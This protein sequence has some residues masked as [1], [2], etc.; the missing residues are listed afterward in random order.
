M[1]FF[2][3]DNG[4]MI[5]INEVNYDCSN[6]SASFTEGDQEKVITGSK[7]PHDDFSN[8]FKALSLLCNKKLSSMSESSLPYKLSCTGVKYVSAEKYEGYKLSCELSFYRMVCDS[9]IKLMLFIPYDGYYEAEDRNGDLIHDPDESPEQLTDDEIDDI[10]DAFSEAYQYFY[11]NKFKPDE[12]PDLFS[13]EDL[14]NSVEIVKKAKEATESLLAN[15]DIQ[16]IK[17]G[18]QIVYRRDDEKSGKGHDTGSSGDE[19][20][21]EKVSKGK[22]KEKDGK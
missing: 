12:Q 22:K 3:R 1:R 20:G 2:E 14:G 9:K 21:N 18:D 16:E 6:V 13:E 17:I 8:V 4:R 10:E 7:R 19:S 15:K 5:I 11:E